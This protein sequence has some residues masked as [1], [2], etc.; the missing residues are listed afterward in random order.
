[1]NKVTLLS[2]RA[3]FAAV[4]VVLL[5]APGCRPREKQEAKTIC[6][7]SLL[8]R[9]TNV[10]AFADAPLG[11]S[12][13][14]SPYDRTG[15]NAD[16]AKWNKDSLNTRGRITLLDLEGP[17][18]ISR[19]WYAS[20]KA[21]RWL[22]FFDGEPTPRLD[23]TPSGL[24]GVGDR[25]PFVPPLAGH[26]SGGKYSLVPIPFERGLRIEVEPEAVDPTHRNYFHIN[27][28]LVDKDQAA[29][30]QSWPLELTA[31]E[32]NAVIRANQEFETK[33]AHMVEVR[34]VCFEHAETVTLAPG[35]HETFF[36]ETGR[37]CIEGFAV[38]VESPRGG[39][40]IQHEILRKLR[41]QMT[42]D[43]ARCPSVDVPLGDF[44]CNPFYPRSFSSY[45]LGN[46]DG[47]YVS[48]VPMPFK[49]GARCRIV[50]DS[51]VPVALKLGA[52]S[53]SKIQQGKSLR[54]FHSRWSASTT[55]GRPYQMA[56]CSGKGHYVGC[57]LTAIGQDGSWNI[58]EGDEYIIPNRDRNIGQYGTGLEDYFSGA[59]YYTDL[60]DLP[61]HGLIEKGAMRTDQYRF[62]ALDSIAFEEG[63]EVGIE[64]GDG[65][66]SRGYMSSVVCWYADTP[67]DVTISECQEALLPRPVDRFEAAGMMAQLFSL[68]RAKLWQNASDRCQFLASRFAQYPWSE[69]LRLRGL[70]YRERIQGFDAI[71]AEYQ[72]IAGS[73]YQ[74]A[75]RQAQ[76]LLWASENENNAL[77]GMHMR[78][79]YKVWIDGIEV[80]SGKSKARLDVRRLN[81]PPGKHTWEVEFEP[82]MQGSMISMCLRTKWGD[83]TSEGEWEVVSADPLP[84]REVPESFKG[85]SP[86]PNMTVWQ[87]EPNGYICM[88]SGRQVAEVWSFWDGRP[89]VR[90]VRLRQEWTCGNGQSEPSLRAKEYERNDLELK[91]HTIE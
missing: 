28:T 56:N 90:R 23:L 31:H 42:W 37:G 61:F 69:L 30:T 58:L 47:V 59:Y 64:F 34:D 15:G 33:D 25:F 54:Y 81:L 21:K 41:L 39:E 2:Y 89:K 10:A 63:L 22:F 76:D 5:L 36:G 50:N 84:G 51:T 45:W 18:Y 77:L 11:Q 73:K 87:F 1:M 79:K 24:F 44:F 70:A 29:N 53:K 27:Y 60:F 46:I 83:V 35:A 40:L 85:G 7:V 78:G 6:L 38:D 72:K 88:Q 74:P 80:A 9:M 32:S 12:Y 57:L 4:A 14:E 3:A 62:H 43:G 86:L 20:F 82:T 19:I 13:L 71:K 16:W 48:R 68:E 75:A 55:S 66:R 49:K 65:N 17:G 91:A 52:M 67:Q 26:S 8:E